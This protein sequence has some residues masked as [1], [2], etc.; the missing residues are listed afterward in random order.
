M[1]IK[2]PTITSFS[3][4]FEGIK[5]AFGREPNFKIHVVIASLTLVMAALLGFGSLEWLIL[6]FTISLV[7]ILELIN[8][9]LEAIVNLVSPEIKEEA[10]IAKDVSAGAVL[11]SAITAII[12]A[13]ILFFPKILILFLT[14]QG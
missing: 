9:A 6:L 10:R 1:G 11:I 5:T 14:I 7:L 12:V 13:F 4:A 2:H 3:F 8:T